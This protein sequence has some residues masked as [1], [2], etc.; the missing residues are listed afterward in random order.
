MSGEN[1][2]FNMLKEKDLEYQ[3]T[4][5]KYDTNWYDGNFNFQI[6]FIGS[7]KGI[8]NLLH[9]D[10]VNGNVE[11]IKTLKSLDDLKYTYEI[12]TNDIFK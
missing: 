5:Y 9:F 6:E 7:K 10:E 3:S 8:C 11:L 4:F 1:I 12:L 2:S